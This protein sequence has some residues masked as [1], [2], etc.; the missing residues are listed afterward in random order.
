MDKD[1]K[2]NAEVL[3]KKMG[4]NMTIA[5]NTFVRQCLR[6]DSIPFQIKPYDDYKSKIESS[7]RQ[8]AEGNL[9]SFSI[10]ELE[11]LE[12]MD[13][14]EAQMFVNVRRKESKL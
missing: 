11:T 14:N 10:D 5:V 13:T 6:E 3:F 2:E 7:L 8:A 1:I 9:I 4:L 12:D